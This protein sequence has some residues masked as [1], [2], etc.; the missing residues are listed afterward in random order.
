MKEKFNNLN[1]IW[2]TLISGQLIFLLV[3]ILVLDQPTL[4]GQ[5]DF[6]YY[7][8]LGF[9]VINIALSQ[10]I[11]PQL[12]QKGK[13]K[14]INEKFSVFQQANI[15]KGALLESGSLLSIVVLFL[16]GNK[17]LI[18]IVVVIVIAM[19]VQRPTPD[20]FTLEMELTS[21]EKEQI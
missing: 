13:S 14:P 7:L 17:L 20:K 4:A 5:V 1:I 10:I 21:E 6:L 15:V 2:L 11:Y 3:V 12:L 8:A 19:A 18:I 9:S 16:T